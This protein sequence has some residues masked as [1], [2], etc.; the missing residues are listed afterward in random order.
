MTHIQ[1]ESVTYTKK[2]VAAIDLYKLYQLLT[3]VDYDKNIFLSL[4][5]KNRYD[6]LRYR[7]NSKVSDNNQLDIDS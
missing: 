3:T 7:N 4:A 6:S 5:D 2:N 1:L